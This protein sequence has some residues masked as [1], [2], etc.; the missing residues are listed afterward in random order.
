M[1]SP[2]EALLFDRRHHNSFVTPLTNLSDPYIHSMHTFQTSTI[3]LIHALEADDSAVIE[4]AQNYTLQGIYSDLPSVYEQVTF[5]EWVED[6]MLKH[7]Q[8]RTVEQ[9]QYLHIVELQT[10]QGPCMDVGSIVASAV[11]AGQEWHETAYDPANLI[12]DPDALWFFTSAS[13]RLETVSIADDDSCPICTS[14]FDAHTH[15]PKRAPCTHI[16]CAPCL[17]SWLL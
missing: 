8:R 1:T 2:I 12:K 11:A 4:L 7:P 10:R 9:H 16:F 6:G 3:S 15:I 14:L 13:Q 17:S 5:R